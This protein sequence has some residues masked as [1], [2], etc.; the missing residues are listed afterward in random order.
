MAELPTYNSR[1]M[2]GYL[3]YLGKHY[4]VQVLAGGAI[5]TLL[6]CLAAWLG[7]K[8]LSFMQRVRAHSQ[9]G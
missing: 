9:S 6:G 4:P 5:G 7:I 2:K 1:I 8:Y 3:Q